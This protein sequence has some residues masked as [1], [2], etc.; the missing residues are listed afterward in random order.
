MLSAPRSGR[1]EILDFLRGL[2]ILGMLVANI[3]W[4][5]GNSMSRVIEPDIT[6]VGA[7]LLQYLFFDQRFMPLFCFLFGAAFCVLQ[8]RANSVLDFKRQYLKRMLALF[9]I[10][11]LHAY[12]LWP[13]DILITYSVC[14]VLLLLFIRCNVITLIVWGCLFKSINLAFGQ[15]PEMYHSTLGAL[16]FSWWVEIGDAP[17]SAVQ[18]YA[19]SY[20]DL[21]SYNAW[22]NQFLQWT[23]LPYFRIWNSLG[24]MLIGIALYKTG[25]LTGERDKRFYLKMFWVSLAIS[26]PLIV[27]GVFARIGINPTVSVYFGFV[28]TL[29][30]RNL[31]FRLGCLIGSISLLALIHLSWKHIFNRVKILIG[32]A[33]RLAL[34]NYLFQSLFFILVFHFLYLMPFDQSDHDIMLLL[35]FMMWFLHITLSYLW[36][37]LYRKGP[38]EYFYQKLTNLF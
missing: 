6:S 37:K 31:T 29:P 2:A 5:V 21:F 25:V 19:G 27:Y 11:V 10:G 14:G 35:V 3:P 34:S 30:L 16:L 20:T 23:A 24:L 7:W 17:I 38:F 9:I 18:A 8:E 12:L 15:W 1:Y 26:L 36:L 32:N 4:H 33:G 13:G 22:R 28:E